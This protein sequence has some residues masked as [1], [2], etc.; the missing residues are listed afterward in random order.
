MATRGFIRFLLPAAART[1]AAVDE[2]RSQF[3]HKSFMGDSL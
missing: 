2:D 3:T 1:A